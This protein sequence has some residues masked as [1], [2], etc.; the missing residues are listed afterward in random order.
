MRTFFQAQIL[1]AYYI[2]YTVFAF[3]SDKNKA[4]QTGD[5]QIDVKWDSRTHL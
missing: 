4:S 2:G 3:F 5:G 1:H